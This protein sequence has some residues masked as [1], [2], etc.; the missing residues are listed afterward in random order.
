MLKGR[1]ITDPTLN[2]SFTNRILK[3][4]RITDYDYPP[5]SA[6]PVFLV[7]SASIHREPDKLPEYGRSDIAFLW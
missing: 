6:C 4:E 2:N 1:I 5:H 7:I 3:E